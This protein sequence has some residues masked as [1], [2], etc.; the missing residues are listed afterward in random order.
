MGTNL[1]SSTGSSLLI[2]VPDSNRHPSPSW[3]MYVPRLFHLFSVIGGKVAKGVNVSSRDASMGV[4][5][6][7]GIA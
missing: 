1:Q 2:A 6:L 7:S 4:E 5:V 3:Y